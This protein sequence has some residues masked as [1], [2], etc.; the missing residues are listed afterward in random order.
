MNK[1][2]SIFGQ[3]LQIFPKAEFNG[4]VMETKAE[5]KVKGFTSWEQFVA[6]LFCQL[7]QAHSLR[8]IGGGLATCLGKVKHLGIQ[9]ALHAPPYL[10]QTSTDPGNSTRRCFI[11][12]VIDA[13][14]SLF[15]GN[16]AG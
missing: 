15:S 9:D 2:S 12:S 16:A 4:A 7:G 10:M 5:R 6:T 14:A 11:S 13:D 8:E 1:F 3:I